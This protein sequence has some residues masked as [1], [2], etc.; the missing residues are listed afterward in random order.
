MQTLAL[1]RYA[2]QLSVNACCYRT[3]QKNSERMAERSTRFLPVKRL[4]Y[5][6]TGI[7]LL[8]ATGHQRFPVSGS[9]SFLATDASVITTGI[10]VYTYYS[11]YQFFQIISVHNCTLSLQICQVI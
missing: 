5:T 10:V 1:L 8:N 9:H 6:R 2:L 11:M 4:V 7:L 3:L